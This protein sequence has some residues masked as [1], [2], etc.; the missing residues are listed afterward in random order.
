MIINLTDTSTREIHSQLVR[1]RRTIGPATGLVLTLI[2]VSQDA[3]LSHARKVASEAASTHPSRVILLCP[4]AA[5]GPDQLNAD[6]HISE[7][8]AGD[9]ITLR[10]A[11]SF[12]SHA[13]S[14]VLPLLLPDSP[15][16]VWW[17]GNAPHHPSADPIGSLADRRITNVTHDPAALRYLAANY[18]PGDTDLSWTGL[19]RLRTLL[20]SALDQVAAPIISGRVTAGAANSSAVLLTSWLSH[21]LQVPITRAV[22]PIAGLSSVHL[23][24]AAGQIAVVKSPDGNAVTFDVP[25]HPQRSWALKQRTFSELMTEELAHLDPDEIY[26]KTLQHLIDGGQR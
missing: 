15:T 25:G 22:G 12:V 6:I 24:S 13:R 5:D 9:L 14:V 4:M 11:G 17:P 7:G 3:S 1:A 2:V 16:A 26:A 19:T 20:A 18:A 21:Q 23:D 8:I 10:L